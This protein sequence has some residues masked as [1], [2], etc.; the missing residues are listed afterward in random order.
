MALLYLHYAF[1]FR[2]VMRE[3]YR[4]SVDF[5]LQLNKISAELKN[6]LAIAKLK[7]LNSSFSVFYVFLIVLRVLI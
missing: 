7:F 6:C 3:T 5:S 2:I 4:I 1:F